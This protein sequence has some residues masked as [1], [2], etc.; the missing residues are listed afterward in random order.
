M[1]AEANL[2]TRPAQQAAAQKHL[3]AAAALDPESW[4]TLYHFAFHLAELRQIGPALHYAQK[5]VALAGAGVDAWHL[6]GL[7]VAARKEL[8]ESLAVLETVLDDGDDTGADLTRSASLADTSL[9]LASVLPQSTGDFDEDSPRDATDDL[10]AV[11][12]LR[13]TKNVVIEALE[14]AE[15]ALLDQQ[16]TMAWFAKAFAEVK[17]RASLS[18]P[19]VA[20]PVGHVMLDVPTVEQGSGAKRAHS[21][22]GRKRSLRRHAEPTSRAP[23]GAVSRDSVISHDFSANTA[24]DNPALNTLTSSHSSNSLTDDPSLNGG[25]GPQVETNRRATKLLVDLWLMSAASY[26]RAGRL[27][28]AKGAIAEAEQ[29]DPD[30]ADV[31]AQVSTSRFSWPGRPSHFADN[32]PPSSSRTCHCSPH[33]TPLAP[34]CSRRSPS[35]PTTRRPSSCCRASTSPW[36]R[37]T[38]RG[39]RSPRAS[40]TR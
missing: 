17:A 10:A 29:L 5:A 26:R 35:L 3:E 31:W 16:A 24:Q 11:C 15:A 2:E 23:S 12:Q 20:S 7:L 33:S 14:G 32:P 27:E 4:T 13:M 21:I 25:R 1:L 39:L 37:A 6:L 19:R 22:L 30:D 18:E 34:R 28:D 38:Q 9:G 8:N 36:R 40:W